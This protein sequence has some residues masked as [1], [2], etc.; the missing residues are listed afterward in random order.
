MQTITCFHCKK[1][2]ELGSGIGPVKVGFRDSCSACHSDLH[3]CRNCSFY[4]QGSHH[5]CRES[6]AE[7]VKDKELANVCEYFR[8]KQGSE[9][10]AEGSK[11]STLKAL[12]DLFK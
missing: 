2:V 5:E 8:P 9:N 1:V 7:W 4:D 10:D 12:D 6:Q 11:T 3:A